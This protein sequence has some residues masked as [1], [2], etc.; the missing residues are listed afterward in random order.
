MDRRSFLFSLGSAAAMATGCRAI[1]SD[2]RRFRVL[3]YNTHHGE[4]EDGR[5]D[6]GRIARVVRESGADLVALQELDI[7]TRRTGG[8]DQGEEYR[9]LIGFEGRFGRAIDFQGGQYGQMLLSR[10]PMEGFE[11]LELPNPSKREQRIAVA[12]RIR[13][14]GGPVIRFVGLHLDATRD[15]GDRILQAE[16]LVE[17]FGSERGA[18]ILAGDFNDTPGSRVMRRFEERWADAAAGHPEPTNPAGTP[19]S[20]I[21]FVLHAGLRGWR[22]GSSRVLPESVAS[23]HRPL[24]VEFVR[25]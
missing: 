23:D 1:P 13:L 14:P 2:V 5:L 21:D 16:R 11:V 24:L 12:T 10:W 6:L 4:G 20:R 25:D 8:V 22:V 17:A 18:T 15:D 9:R 7:R 3:T 19:G